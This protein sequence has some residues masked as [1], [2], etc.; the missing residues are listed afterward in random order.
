MMERKS[1]EKKQE[2]LNNWHMATPVQ[3]VVWI[4]PKQDNLSKQAGKN[5]NIKKF[6]TKA[7]SGR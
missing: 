7:K 3:I 2:F 4:M 6:L 1:K 5:V